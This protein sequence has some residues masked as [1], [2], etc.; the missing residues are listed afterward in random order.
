MSSW[1]LILKITLPDL[2]TQDII[3]RLKN[4]AL[5]RIKHR[6][7]ENHWKHKQS[8]RSIINYFLTKHKNNL[9]KNSFN[10]NNET[11]GYLQ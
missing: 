5:E 8:L 6:L 3:V 1:K 4:V 2:K 9:S 11:T 7:V 10:Y